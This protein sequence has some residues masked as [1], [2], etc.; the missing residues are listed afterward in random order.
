M[1]RFAPPCRSAIFTCLDPGSNLSFGSQAKRF[2]NHRV[3][4]GFST[5]SGRETTTMNHIWT[6]DLSALKNTGNCRRWSITFSSI[7]WTV[8]EKNW[9]LC[10]LEIKPVLQPPW[11]F[12]I[13]HLSIT[14]LFPVKKCAWMLMLLAASA[15]G[16]CLHLVEPVE[17]L[18]THPRLLYH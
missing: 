15:T 17:S 18:E 2:G 6:R 16:T 4:A 5:I 1:R 13:V 14:T 11:R 9:L 12:Q 7:P 10:R 8:K 3:R